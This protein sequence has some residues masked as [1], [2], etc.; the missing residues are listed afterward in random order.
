MGERSDM[1]GRPDD[2]LSYGAH[3][4][5]GRTLDVPE[6][7]CPGNYQGRHRSDPQQWVSVRCLSCVLDGVTCTLRERGA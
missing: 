3:S 2:S 6:E 5:L 1:F 4:P 7:R